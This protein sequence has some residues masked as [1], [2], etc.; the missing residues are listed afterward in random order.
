MPRQVLLQRLRNFTPWRKSV[1]PVL[2][3]VDFI[4]FDEVAK[5]RQVHVRGRQDHALLV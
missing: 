4:S 3:R 2:P 1:R 5:K